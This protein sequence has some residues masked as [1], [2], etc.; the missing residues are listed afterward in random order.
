MGQITLECVTEQIQNQIE[1]V[2]MDSNIIEDEINLSRGC[3]R[4]V[5][6]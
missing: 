2:G 3:E 1:D 6:L 5:Q 4:K